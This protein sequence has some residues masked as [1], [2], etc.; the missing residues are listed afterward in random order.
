MKKKHCISWILTGV[1]T[2]L[3]MIQFPAVAAD[4]VVVVPLMSSG[5]KIPT[6]K[7]KTGRVWMDRNLGAIRV[8]GSKSDSLAFGWLYQWGRPADGHE[9][10][11][12]IQAPVNRFSNGDVPGHGRFIWVDAAPYDW[13]SPQNDNLWQGEEGVNNPCPSGF[14][15][16]TES[17]W[18]DEIAT[19]DTQ[20]SEGAYESALHLSKG[21]RRNQGGFIQS[22]YDQAEYWTSSVDGDGSRMVLISG[23]GI[24]FHTFERANGLSVRCIK[25]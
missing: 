4:K 14:R 19:W 23:S 11:D 12:S 7:S 3:V 15:L 21:G 16:P 8:A 17:E 9:S 6:V 10:R 18:V 1:V 13:R 20:D 22:A 5:D 25:N 24:N 2:S